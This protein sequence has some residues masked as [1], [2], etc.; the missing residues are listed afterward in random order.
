MACLVDEKS[1]EAFRAL[2]KMA[3]ERNIEVGWQPYKEPDGDI[4]M[5]LSGGGRGIPPQGGR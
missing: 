5:S 3:R 1:F 4:I 2:R